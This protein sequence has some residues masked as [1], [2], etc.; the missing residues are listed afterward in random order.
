MRPPHPQQESVTRCRRKATTSSRS[1]LRNQPLFLLAPAPIE[2]LLVGLRIDLPPF[3][4]Y[5]EARPVAARTQ[6]Q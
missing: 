3:S 5:V 4:T 2:L 1:Y 6:I